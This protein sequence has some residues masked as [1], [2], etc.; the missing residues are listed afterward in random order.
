MKQ[1]FHITPRQ[2]VPTIMLDGLLAKIGPRSLEL[3]E[4]VPAVYLFRTIEDAENALSNWLGE[5]F[6]EDEVLSLLGVTL[7]EDIPEDPMSFEY[8]VYRDIPGE[9]I[10]ILVEDLDQIIDIRDIN[11]SC[12]NSDQDPSGGRYD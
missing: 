4:P 6:D 11:G 9:R 12:P 10:V 2:N 8:C 7:P 3:G 1:L 5:A